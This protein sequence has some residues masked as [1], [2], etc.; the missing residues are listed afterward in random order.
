MEG[1]RTNE[2]AGGQG[3]GNPNTIIGIAIGIGSEQDTKDT[4]PSEGHEEQ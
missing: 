1:K 2:P 4:K 3:G